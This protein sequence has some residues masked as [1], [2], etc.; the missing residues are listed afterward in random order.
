MEKKCVIGVFTSDHGIRFLV[1]QLIDEMRFEETDISVIKADGF[2]FTTNLGPLKGANLEN[3]GEKLI[4]VGLSTD[5]AR[6]FK[7]YLKDGGALVAISCEEY[8]LDEITELLGSYGAI[9]IQV[10][11]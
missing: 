3:L 6:Y 1:N 10:A 7:G 9:D 11:E 2:S 5:L 4:H 8:R